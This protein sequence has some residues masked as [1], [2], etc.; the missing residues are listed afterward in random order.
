M[1]TFDL[2]VLSISRYG[3]SIGGSLLIGTLAWP[4]EWLILIG[5]FLSTLGAGLQ[6][7]TGAPRL[8]QAI[9]KDGVIPFLR[10]F[11]VTTKGGEPFRALLLTGFIS[12]LGILVGNLDYVAPII[13]M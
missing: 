8:L 13:T 10:V 1:M 6:T 9:A 12:W 2:S 4:H 3:K 7:L 5:S 11:S